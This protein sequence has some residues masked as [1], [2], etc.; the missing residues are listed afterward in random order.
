MTVR[1][2]TKTDFGERLEKVLLKQIGI[3]QVTATPCPIAILRKKVAEMASNYKGQ[4]LSQTSG[5]WL[6]EK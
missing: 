2:T 3:W 4:S 1:A 6:G 5:Y